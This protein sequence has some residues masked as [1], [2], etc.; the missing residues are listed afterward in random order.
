MTL[1]PVN[2][3]TLY[4]V[5]VGPGEPSWLTMRAVE[6]LKGAD[7][8]AWFAKEGRPGNGRAIVGELIGHGRDELPLLYPVTTE[9]PVGDPGYE[10]MIGSFYAEAAYRVEAEL[11]AG[12]SVAVISE[13]DPFLYGSF[14]HIWRRLRGRCPI[15]IVPGVTGMSACW[16][17]AGVPITWGDDVL[18]VLPGTL[19]EDDLT[20]RLGATDAAVIMKLGHHLAKVRRAILTAGLMSRAVYVERG[21]M[22]GEVILPLT[23]K[24]DDTAPYFSMILIPGEGR[25]S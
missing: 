3:G 21:S 2:P 10:Q 18:T 13:G 22:P 14:M 8:I 5:G 24:L 19:P 4:G 6:V 25:R 16:S 1:P 12:K 23:E 9:L 17:R 20:R 15:E 7:V 11:G